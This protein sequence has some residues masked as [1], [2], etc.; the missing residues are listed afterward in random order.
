MTSNHK[1]G[2]PPSVF[3]CEY[4][5]SP[6]KDEAFGTLTEVEKERYLLISNLGRTSNKAPGSK[7]RTRTKN[8]KTVSKSITI[9]HDGI[10][11]HINNAPTY[12]IYPKIFHR[13]LDQVNICLAKWRRVFII[14]FDL[15]Q[16]FHTPTNAMVSR[17]R[18]NVVRRIERAYG[19][20]E[21]GY[22][23]VREQEKS[24]RQHYHFAMFL[25]GD[26]VNH[27]AVIGEVIR[28]AWERVKVGN[29]VHIPK[30]CYYNLV[31]GDSE[32]MAEVV[33]RL[34][35]LSKQRGKGYRPPQTNDF[36]T[37]RLN[38][39]QRYSFTR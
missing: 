24:K 5:T 30:G 26:K 2:F 11:Y 10:E 21:V 4:E 6:Y 15:H 32:T 37:S 22:I 29:S 25:D 3:R 35:Y 9:K 28:E 27:S 23:W 38:K 16:Q 39:P 14:R 33:Y 19:L 20:Y 18:D 12:G 31:E 7:R 8:R 13:G 17:F 36:S 34:S 1:N